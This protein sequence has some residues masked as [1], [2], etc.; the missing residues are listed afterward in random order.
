MARIK[1]VPSVTSRFIA[2]V[3]LVLSVDRELN[4]IVKQAAGWQWTVITRDIHE[5]PG[6]VREPDLRLAVFDDQSVAAPDRGWALAQIRRCAS[7]ASIV[8]VAGQHDPDNERQARARGV[9]FYTSK[10][11]MA[12]DTGLLLERLHRMHSPLRGPAPQ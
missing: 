1:S 12:A 2:P 3:L 9:L 11:L 8:Y 6:L 10:P 5:L 4:R 7:N